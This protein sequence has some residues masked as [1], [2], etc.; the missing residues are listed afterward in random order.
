MY[1]KIKLSC[2]YIIEVNEYYYVGK[3]IDWFSRLQSHYTMLKQNK[4]HS[5]K[6][7]SLYND[8]GIGRFNFR[9]LEYISLTE[10]KKTSQTKGKQLVKDFNKH[11]LQREKWWMSQY[12]TNFCLNKDD[13]HF[14]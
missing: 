5:P 13:K 11:L 14:S 1:Q 6:L 9:V 3:S 12:S 7:Q 8:F 2:I 4:H 10:Y